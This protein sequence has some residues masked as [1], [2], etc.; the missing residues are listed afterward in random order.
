MK[1]IDAIISVIL[2][3]MITVALVATSYAWFS[4]LFTTVMGGGTNVTQTGVTGI[5]TAFDIES[6]RNVTLTNVTVVVR[7]TGTVD[8]DLNDAS[9]YIADQYAVGPS[10]NQV[11]T[12]TGTAIASKIVTPNA[13]AQFNVTVPTG[14]VPCSKTLR[15]SLGVGAPQTETIIC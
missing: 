1:G 11:L 14:I 10:V 7:N 12:M 8:M 3:L 9:T 15:I 2:L 6:A 4:G 5:Q 13:L